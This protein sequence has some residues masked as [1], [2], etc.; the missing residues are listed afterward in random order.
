MAESRATVAAIDD[1]IDPGD[2][3]ARRAACIG[4]NHI[5]EIEIALAQPVAA[6]I[7]AANPRTGRI[8]LSVGD[9]IAGG[10]LVLAIDN[11]AVHRAADG[12]VSRTRAA[13]L[14][15]RLAPMSPAQRLAAFRREVDG[16]IVFTTSFGLEDQVITH[17]LSTQGI[18]VDVATLDTGRLFP[19]TY[20]LWAETER[21]Y[22]LRI[23]AVYPQAVDLEA[24]VAKQG[25]D[26]FYASRAARL[27]CCHVRKVEPLNR[28]LAGA[29]GWIAGLRA[30][31]SS[32]R[33]DM[34]MVTAESDRNLLKLSP[35]FDWTR[36]AVLGFA[37]ARDVP[38]NPLHAS[39]FA[40]IGCAP[41]TRAIA[42]GEPERAG[43]WWWEDEGKREC[44]LHLTADRPAVQ[45]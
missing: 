40:S 33:H 4:R 21:R 24:L 5:G 7:Y 13:H 25:I 12:A 26:G 19:E 34:A 35:L 28:A 16:K 1:A 27:A 37:T 38:I 23:R 17:L 8:V 36:D 6:D 43:R 22:G 32:H 29:A 14:D 10:G 20:A 41:C 44:G 30:D 9:R 45:R 42:P 18:D 15:R 3:S 31:Q 39:G 2:L 11:A